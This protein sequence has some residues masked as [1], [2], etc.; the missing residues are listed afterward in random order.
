[1]NPTFTHAGRTWT[2][3]RHPATLQRHRRGE[4]TDAELE[5]Q[6][7]YIRVLIDGSRRPV[8]LR[9]HLVPDAIRQAKAALR[10]R[11]KPSFTALLEAARVRQA[12]T[13][14]SLVAEWVTLGCPHA[15]GEPRTPAQRDRITTTLRIPLTW[16]GSRG[17]SSVRPR[18]MHDY[19]AH[20]RS[21]CRTGDTGERA[22]DL[23]LAALSV[24]CQWAVATERLQANPFATRPRFRRAER[25]TSCHTYMPGS[26]DEL[27]RLIGHLWSDPADL[28]SMVAGGHLLCSALT[29]LRPGEPGFL[30]RRTVASAEGVRRP[31]AW[32][33]IDQ[34][35][36]PVTKLAVSR[37]KHGQ[38]LAVVVRPALREFLEAWEAW[39]DAH[40][41]TCQH[42]F[43]DPNTAGQPLVPVGD[44]GRTGTLRHRLNAA[45]SALGVGERHPHGMRAFY[46]RVRRAM[47]MDDA[48]IASELGQSG[49]EGLIRR[50]YGDPQDVRGDRAFDWL[51]STGEPCWK[52]LR[53]APAAEPRLS[54]PFRG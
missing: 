40:L 31:G 18:D 15:N 36:S 43:P 7:W 21:T 4:L 27:H 17:A 48:T 29:G 5:H 49:G 52:S 3:F 46:V 14:D 13:L 9:T 33:T 32:Y 26:D 1:M 2:L 42:L 54:A 37:L 47:G 20:R 24:C 23:E 38:N 10:E 39:L 25:V 19:L 6:P 35:G 41:P 16:W 51:P 12:V 28:V 45:C 8:N 34:D 50:T 53:A 11:H 30:L 22:V 44:S